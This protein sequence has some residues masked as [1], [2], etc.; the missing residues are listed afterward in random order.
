M[1]HILRTFIIEAVALY[2]VT[3]IT[4]G[5]TF[6]NGLQDL[7]VAAIGLAITS[8]LAKPI[9]NLFLLPFNLLTFGF[10]KFLTG[11]IT[12]F[13]T[14]LLLDQFSVG[15]FFF[16]G[17]PGKLIVLPSIGFPAGALSYLVF[18]FLISFVGSILYWLVG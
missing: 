17:Y 10:F 15:A 1:K 3:L 12:L 14:D 6:T 7:I 18:S 8:M 2:L 9:I 13:I 4:T 11:A 16:K 5:L